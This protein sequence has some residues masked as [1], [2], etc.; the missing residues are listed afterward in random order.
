[1]RCPYCG[2]INQDQSTYCVNCGRDMRNVPS[3]HQQQPQ[4]RPGNASNQPARPQQ[5][6]A[7]APNQP[8]KPQQSYAPTPQHQTGRP[9][10][11]QAPVAAP[12][13]RRNPI[14]PPQAPAQRVAAQPAPEPPAPFPPR[15]MDHINTLL[16][17]GAQPYTVVES[18]MGDGKKKI[19]RIAYARCADWQ[20]TATLYKALTEQQEAQ[21]STII[22]QGVLPQQP[23]VYAFTNGQLQF[24]REVRLGGTTS[25]RYV[26]ETG[27]GFANDSVRFVLN[28]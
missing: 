13:S 27:N 17:A 15:T 21:Y 10:Q 3:Q 26:I 6:H 7:P 12:T 18:L 20:Q 24:D 25:N 1:M 16:A 23:N 11:Q 2:G 9:A 8:T 22:I 4:A 14:A 19:V 5:G 28:E